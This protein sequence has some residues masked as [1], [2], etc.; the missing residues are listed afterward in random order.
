MIY[1]KERGCWEGEGEGEG[2]VEWHT[3]Y[4]KGGG[5]DGKEGVRIWWVNGKFYRV[6][7][8]SLILFLL[9]GST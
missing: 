9:Q 3:P 5:E 2:G 6:Y 4:K 8:I 7:F 1:I